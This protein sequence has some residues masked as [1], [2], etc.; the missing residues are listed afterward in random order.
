VFTPEPDE[1]SQGDLM[2]STLRI[3]YYVLV[4]YKK[5]CTH[6]KV[7]DSAMRRNDEINW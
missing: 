4:A 7:K 1:G 2:I 6:S 5:C 3:G